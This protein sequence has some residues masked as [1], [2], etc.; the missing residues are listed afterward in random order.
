[1]LH[2]SLGE[3]CRWQLVVGGSKRSGWRVVRGQDRV[4]V[5]AGGISGRAALQMVVWHVCDDV[6][7][8]LGRMATTVTWRGV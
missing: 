5:P 6:G 3:G 2:A 4:W 8:L 7:V 1:M